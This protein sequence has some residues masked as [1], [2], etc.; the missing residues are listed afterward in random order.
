M[1]PLSTRFDKVA[2]GLSLVCTLHCLLLPVAVVMLP[3]LTASAFGDE[4]FHQWLLLAVLPTSLIALTM[5]CRKHRHLSVIAIGLPG[6][7][8]LFLAAFFGHDLLTEAGEKIASLLGTSLIAFGHLRNHA[9]CKRFRC[10]CET[11]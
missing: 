2:I 8:V 4:G 5:G 3:A 9:L 7:L 6:L 11:D 10:H 1:T